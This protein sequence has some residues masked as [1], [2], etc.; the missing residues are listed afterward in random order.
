MSLPLVRISVRAVVE[1]ML[2]ESDLCPAAGQA[3][4]MREGTLAHQA[5]QAAA[6]AQEETWRSE[7]PLTA[8]YE[9]PE[10]VLQVTGR[11]DGIYM[12]RDDVPVIEEIKLGEAGAALREAHMAQAEMYGHMLSSAEGYPTVRLRVLYAGLSGEPLASYEENL[13]AEELQERFCA[14]CAP[15]AMQAAL[16]VRRRAERDE[17]LRDLPFPYPEWREGQRRFSAGIWKAVEERRR[18]FAQAPTGIGKTMA[19]LWPAMQAVA[20]GK[21]ARAVFLTAR[22]TGRASAMDAARLLERKGARLLAC[23]IAAKDKVCPQPQRDCRPEV[24]PLAEGYYDR[25]P[26]ALAELLTGGVYG[27]EEIAGLARKHRLCPF[28]LSLAAAAEADLT[29]CDYNYVYDPFVSMDALLRAPGGAVLLVDEAHQLAPRVRDCYS[30]SADALQLT[31]IRRAQGAVSGR[32][33]PLYTALTRALRA[34][35]QAGGMADFAEKGFCPPKELDEA[36]EAVRDAAAQALSEGGGR[37][38]ADAFAAGVSWT[39]A[40]ERL[41][42]RWAV[43][44]GGQGKRC[45]IELRLLDAAPEILAASRLA[46]GTAYFSATFSPHQAMRRILGG[47]EGDISLTLPSPFAPEQLQVSIAPLDV[48]YA[49]RERTAPQVARAL[50]E[51][52]TAGRENALVFFPSYAYMER[53]APLLL[54]AAAETDALWLQERRGMTEAEKQEML[55]ALREDAD[56][57]ARLLCVLGGAFSEAVDLPGDRLG[58]IAVVSA[59]MP[60]PDA[61]GEALRSYY[62]EQGEDGYFLTMI[63]PGVNRVIQAAGRLIRTPEDRG[64]LLLVDQRYLR[65]PV[66]KLLEG[67]LIGDALAL[68]A[69]DVQTKGTT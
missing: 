55:A 44:T 18:I 36:M 52:L 67:T 58:C 10:V 43:L 30:A 42:E 61:P 2:H 37:P 57:P 49:A 11:A 62:D 35:E 48:R 14:L 27:R 63:L 28:E 21:A 66:R 4:R 8:R 56:P 29:V 25:L 50:T 46:R 60:Q 59:G 3:R 1:T 41:D 6:G 22:V 20:R 17:S 12:G 34:L 31:E 26:A 7:V 65:G 45:R 69:G 24:C 64:R 9:G 13:S 19:A 15:A 23:E 68:S 40:R 51:H 16:R 54:E 47:E 32:K 53:I 39:M 33:H 5:R 38:A